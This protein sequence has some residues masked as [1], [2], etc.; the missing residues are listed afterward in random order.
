MTIMFCHKCHQIAECK[1]ENPQPTHRSIYFEHPYINAYIRER[2][3]SHCKNT[4]KTYEIGEASFL[5][6]RKILEM[7]SGIGKYI[8][9]TWAETRDEFFQPLHA[10]ST[11]DMELLRKYEQDLEKRESLLPENV[12]PFPLRGE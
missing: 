1:V 11:H 9:N 12:I 10:E 2:T 3:C 8:E 7:S 6:L 5:A 4:F